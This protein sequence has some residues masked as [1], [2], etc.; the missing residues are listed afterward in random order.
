MKRVER[1]SVGTTEEASSTTHSHAFH[2]TLS[3]SL[4]ALRP[5]GVARG[6]T[7]KRF[8]RRTKVSH[9]GKTRI[10]SSRKYGCILGHG[11]AYSILILFIFFYIN[12]DSS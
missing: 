9:F 11:E 8:V 12:I 5:G 6:Q 4:S 2:S 7:A 3:L 10:I 1:M